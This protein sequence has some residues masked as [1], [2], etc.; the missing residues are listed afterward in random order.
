MEAAGS[1]I[2]RDGCHQIR[3]QLLNVSVET[4][5]TVLPCISW[6]ALGSSHGKPCP[7]PNSEESSRITGCP[8]DPGGPWAW[9]AVAVGD[10]SSILPTPP[11]FVLPS[12]GGG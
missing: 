3:Y 7:E 8:E 2:P 5:Y 10:S 11:V 1:S 6:E 4:V 12:S 9:L